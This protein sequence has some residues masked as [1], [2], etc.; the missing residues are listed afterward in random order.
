MKLFILSIAVLFSSISFAQGYFQQDV[1]YQINVSLDDAEHELSGDITIEYTNNSPDALPFIW[2]HLW[3]NA[4]KNGKTALAK[5]QYRDGE[6]FMFYAMDKSLGF[7]DQ[8]DFQINGTKA[9]WSYHSEHIDIAKITLAQ[10]LAPGASLTITTPFHV[11]LPS[12]NISRLGHID[13]SYQITQWYPKPAVYDRDG[14]HEMPYLNQG[15]FY[16][17]YGSFDVSITLPKNYVVGATGDLVDGEEE[18]AFLN[19]LDIQTRAST[20]IDSNA[21]PASSEEFKTLRYKQNKVHDFAWFADKRW[22]VLKDEVVLPHSGEIV[23]TWSMFTPENG[24]LWQKSPE[25]LKDAI[26]Y[27]SLWNGDY[28]Y[29]QVTAVDGTISAGGG[30][31]YPNV[32]VIGNSGT[33]LGLETVIIHEVGHNWFYGILGSNERTNAWMDEGINSFNETRYFRVKYN[34][35]LTFG[36]GILSPNW[37][38]RLELNTLSYRMRDEYAYL[39]SARNGIDQPMQCHSDSLSSINYGTITYKKTAVAFDHLKGY[40]GDEGFDKAMQAYFE[41]WKFKHP[42]PNDLR[43]AVEKSTGKDLSWFFDDV[44]NTNG[45]IDYAAVGTSSKDGAKM[46][47]IK[48]RGDLNVPFQVSF[49]GEEGKVIAEQWYEGI[50]KGDKK[51]IAIPEGTKMVQVDGNENMLEYDRQNDQLRTS[52]LFKTVEPISFR[53]GTRIDNPKKSELFWIPLAAWNEQNNF[54]LGVNIHNTALP[55]RDWEFSL[56]PLYSFSQNNINGFARVSKFF[57]KHVLDFQVQK[58]TSRDYTNNYLNYSSTSNY[59]RPS[60]SFNYILNDAP[61][62]RYKDQLTFGVAAAFNS[63]DYENNSEATNLIFVRDYIQELYAPE[64]RYSANF[65]TGPRVSH[66]FGIGTRAFMVNEVGLEDIGLIATADYEGAFE[67]NQKGKKIRWKGFGGY[68]LNK[69][70]Y[71]YTFSGLG[72]SANNDIMFDQLFLQRKGTNETLNRQISNG[73][74]SVLVDSRSFEWILN[75]MLEYELP[76]TPFSVWASGSITDGGFIFAQEFLGINYHFNYAAGISFT[77]VRDALAIH[78]PLISNRLLDDPQYEPWETIM[79]Q[80]NID[81]FNPWMALRRIGK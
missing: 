66:E 43:E 79:F 10:P 3:P 42:S 62:D 38:E 34:D 72:R 81:K 67:Y 74:E 12:G 37:L 15:E 76:K 69:D 17:E 16:S 57:G 59:V 36:S 52:G 21:F 5:Q 26:H 13:Q 48:N 71:F 45:K 49:L 32:T 60:I 7:I 25:Y 18:L 22:R 77:L 55:A 56:S 39:I 9:E 28:P 4:Y 51:S 14:W 78:V 27:Y 68:N 8:L 73:S 6:L 50:P 54:M 29:K 11:K 35:S 23:T 70:T 44:I 30:M 19:A 2:M 31:E 20:E 63:V 1:D 24:E 65:Q 64:I 75:G 41:A 80:F 46:V 40:L 58:F 53:F 33:A 47:S 61:R